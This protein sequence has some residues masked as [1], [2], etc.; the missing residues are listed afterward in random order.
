[1]ANQEK[2][3]DIR[4]HAGDLWREEVFTDRRVGT[5]QRLVPVDADGKPDSARQVVYSGQTSL[6]TPAGT[7]PV[8]FEIEAGS[9]GEAA[10]KFGAAAEV[11]IEDT[12]KRLDELRR[13]AASSI[14]VPERGAGGAGGLGGPGGAGGLGGPGGKIRMP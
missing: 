10:E 12:M 9:L 6:L 8:S 14:I 11:A 1:M 13:E 7:L 5:I 3:L 4:M 2:D